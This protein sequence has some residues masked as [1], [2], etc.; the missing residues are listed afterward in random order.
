MVLCA[1]PLLRRG[2]RM[3]L[4]SLLRWMLWEQEQ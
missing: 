1:V 2:M 4:L 3:L